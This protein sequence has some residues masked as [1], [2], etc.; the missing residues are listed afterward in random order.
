MLLLASSFGANAS[1]SLYL[2]GFVEQACAGVTRC[3]H[4]RV[5]TVYSGEAKDKIIVH[6]DADSVIFDPENYRL[7]L[8]QSH[9]IEGS[10]LQLLLAPSGNEFR[11]ETIWIGE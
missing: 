3:F 11:A 2:L 9:I 8:A 4:F 5:E 1:G 7:T 10:H 6:Y